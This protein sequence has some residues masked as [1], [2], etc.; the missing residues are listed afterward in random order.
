MILWGTSLIQTPTHCIM[1][2]TK[3]IDYFALQD[4]WPRKKIY[5]LIFKPYVFCLS[6]KRHILKFHDVLDM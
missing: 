3:L 2:E 1:K 6:R 5:H 4:Q